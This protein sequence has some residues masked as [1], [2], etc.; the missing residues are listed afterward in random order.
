MEGLLADEQSYLADCGYFYCS[1][2]CANYPISE[3]SSDRA[4]ERAQIAHGRKISEKRWKVEAYFGRQKRRWQCI[5]QEWRHNIQRCET[6]FPL[7]AALWNWEGCVV[8]RKSIRKDDDTD[9]E[10]LLSDD[11]TDMED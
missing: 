2:C 5:N 8:D 11:D 4:T 1:G 9:T 7:L 3:W 6:I 10:D